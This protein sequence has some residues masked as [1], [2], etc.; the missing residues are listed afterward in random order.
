MQRIDIQ[1]AD[2]DWDDS[3]R[4]IFEGVP[5]TGEAVTYGWL[6]D[7]TT[8][9]TYVDGLREGLQQEWYDGGELKSELTV[10][11]GRIV[12]PSREWHPNGQLAKEKRFGGDGLLASESTWDEDGQAIGGHG[13]L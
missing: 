4:L 8:L 7:V 1:A 11:K 3:G 6:D 2:V 9:A 13:K 10:Q 12:G 5:F